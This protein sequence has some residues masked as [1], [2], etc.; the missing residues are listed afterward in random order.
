MHKDDFDSLLILFEVCMF[1][2]VSRIRCVAKVCRLRWICFKISVS[3]VSAC[4]QE[5]EL[6]DQSSC[7]VDGRVYMYWLVGSHNIVSK[8]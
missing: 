8:G 4:R 2:D 7:V 1:L 5:V 3:G 6:V